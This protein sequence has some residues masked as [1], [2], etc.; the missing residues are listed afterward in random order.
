[1]ENIVNLSTGISGP[2]NMVKHRKNNMNISGVLV[3]NGISC[4][5]KAAGL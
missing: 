1:M 4:I 3:S 5:L 2:K